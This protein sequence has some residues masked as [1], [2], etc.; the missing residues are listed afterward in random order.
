MDSPSDSNTDITDGL[1]WDPEQHLKTTKTNAYGVVEF[2]VPAT[3]STAK[4]G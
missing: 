3:R 2:P 1:T 4:V